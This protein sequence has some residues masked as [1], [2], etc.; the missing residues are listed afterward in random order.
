MPSQAGRE[1]AL[2][3]PT[4]AH[5]GMCPSSGPTR[6]A[7]THMEKGVLCGEAK[8]GEASPCPVLAGSLPG[9]AQEP[10]GHAPFAAARFVGGAGRRTPGAAPTRAAGGLCC[11]LPFL[12]FSS[13]AGKEGGFSWKYTQK[14]PFLGNLPVLGQAWGMPGLTEVLC[15]AGGLNTWGGFFPSPS[16]P[17]LFSTALAWNWHPPFTG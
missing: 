17:E 10:P 13:S 11:E 6:A 14:C 12:H 7:Q 16:A 15:W 4:G 3:P 1:V 5:L 8:P 2:S 9:P